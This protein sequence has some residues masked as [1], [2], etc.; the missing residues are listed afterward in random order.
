MYLIKKGI[1]VQRLT[2]DGYPFSD[3]TDGESEIAGVDIMIHKEALLVKPED[4]NG[5][6]IFQMNTN[7]S[8]EVAKEEVIDSARRKFR[9]G[10]PGGAPAQEVG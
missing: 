7:M 2:S 6:Y 5:K 8:W 9:Q 1:K 10:P 3:R 4:N